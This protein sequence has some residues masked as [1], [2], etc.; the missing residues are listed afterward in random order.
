[1]TDN[2]HRTLE[3]IAR[4]LPVP[5]PAYDRLLRRRDRKARNRRLSAAVL[6]IAITLLSITGLIRAFGNSER[7]AT[8]PTPTPVDRGIFSGMGGWIAYGDTIGISAM[9]PERP[10]VS[11]RLSTDL[12]EPLAWSSDGSKLLIQRVSEQSSPFG[13][14]LSVLNADGSET[15]LIDVGAGHGLSG[16]SFSPDG[17]KVVYGSESFDGSGPAGIYVIDAAGGIPSLL[18]EDPRAPTYGSRSRRGRMAPTFSPDGSQIAYIEG[19]GDHDNTLRVM[20]ADGSGSRVLLKDQGVMRNSAFSGGLVW[21]PDGRHLAFG[22]GYIPDNIYVVGAD[23]SGLTLAIPDGANPEWSPDG[24]RISFDKASEPAA[25]LMI[26]DA[27]GTHIQQFDNGT[28]GPWN[29]SARDTSGTRDTSLTA[30]ATRADAIIYAIAAL[31][32]V[33]V[34]VLW[35]RRKRKTWSQLREESA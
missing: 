19:M 32:A 11:V 13:V 6:A 9:D 31:A 16:G 34:V 14:A 1:M 33:G 5:E 15:L 10:E 17:S 23:G 20:N 3:R 27:D 35:L 24:S 2:S 4:R 12:V 30:G 25:P 28:S 21:S 7:P 18:P 22:L 26:A 29:P 8:Q